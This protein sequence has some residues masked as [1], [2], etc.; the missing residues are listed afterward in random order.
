MKILTFL[1]FFCFSNIVQADLLVSFIKESSL[2]Y[3]LSSNNYDNSPNNYDNSVNN[4]D[5]SPNNYDNSENNYDNS[6]NNYDNS[7]GSDN[8]LILQD[9]ND[10]FLIGYYVTTKSGLTN[11]FSSKEKI[12]RP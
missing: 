12:G 8:R 4:Y 2:S 11:F 10:S 5:N 7:S 9:G 6:S 3:E 1:L